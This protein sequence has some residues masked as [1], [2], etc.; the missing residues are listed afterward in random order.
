MPLHKQGRQWQER[1]RPIL[2]HARTA[3]SCN[4]QTQ[5]K[6][7]R[8]EATDAHHYWERWLKGQPTNTVYLGKGYQEKAGRLTL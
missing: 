6:W 3:G 7:S 2:L 5:Q 1:G 4:M 8:P